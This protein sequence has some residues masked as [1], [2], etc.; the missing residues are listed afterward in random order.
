MFDRCELDGVCIQPVN[1]SKNRI[2]VDLQ[3]CHFNVQLTLRCSRL[4]GVLSFTLLKPGACL[5]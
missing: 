5:Q 2:M 1:Q 3:G 4:N